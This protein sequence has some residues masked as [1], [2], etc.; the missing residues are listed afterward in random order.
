MGNRRVGY[1]LHA[2][3]SLRK[4]KQRMSNVKMWRC[5]AIRAFIQS[6]IFVFRVGTCSR[7]DVYLVLGH[8]TTCLRVT[9]WRKGRCLQT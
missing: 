5:E 7:L 2:H 4:R 3:G 8:G 1:V 6:S 9:D